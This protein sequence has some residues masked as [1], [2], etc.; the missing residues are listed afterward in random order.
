[1]LGEAEWAAAE[2]IARGDH[3]DPF[4]F[5]GMHVDARGGALIVRAFLPQASR[6]AVVD[7]RTGDVIGEL[8][9]VHEEGLFAGALGQRKEPFPYRLRLQAAN[10]EVELDDPYGF[11]PIL[12]EM[13]VHLLAEGSDERAYE[14]LGAHPREINGVAGV[15]FAVWAPNARR[16]SVVG[17]FND[18]DGRRHAMRL[19][20]EC[21]VWEIFMPGLKQGDLYKY[22]IKTGFGATLPLK[23]DPFGFC[24]E[25]PPATASRVYD[26]G[27][28]RWEDGPWLSARERASARDAPVAIYEVHLGSWRR[29][30]EQNNRYLTYRELA[31]EL[32]AYVKEMG[33]THI[34]LLPVSEYP[35]DGSWGYQPIGLFA[36]TSRFGSPDDFRALVE[37]CHGHGIGVLIDWVP[38]HFPT[39][40]HGLGYFDGTHLYE[41]AD[42]R[43]G[44]HLDWDTLIYN[45]GRREVGNYLIS[46]A[47]LWLD[48]YHVDGLRVDAVAS[49]LYLDYSR[50]PGGWIPNVYGGNENL[51]AIAFLRRLNELAYGK[52][53][54]AI[55]IAEESTAWPMVSRPTYLGGL[56]FGYK[57]NM[58]WMHDTLHYMS[59][60]PVHRRYHHDNLTFGMLYAFTE[61]FILPLSH[62][63][64]VHG[65]GSLLGRMPGDRW[66]KFAN[67]R[68]YFA[69][70]YTHPGKKL[71]FMG[72]EFAQE[73]EWNH[74]TGLEWHLLDDPMHR[75][76]QALVRDL[77]NLYRS[78]PALHVLDCEWQGFEWIDCTNV[79][80]SVVSYI[81]RGHEP[82][83]FVVVVCNFTPVVR[84]G[85][86][87]GVPAAG[88]YAE[89]LNTDAAEYGGSGVGNSGGVE[90]QTIPSHGRPYS[91]ALTLPPLAALVLQPASA[92]TRPA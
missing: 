1:M 27:G 37:R 34:E 21:G 39:D 81:R 23:A 59:T 5:L 63:E 54:G 46:N 80:Q 33:F 72:G 90:A 35:F 24:A 77:N 88:F 75:S 67:L 92:Q 55:T 28:Y 91:L 19:R 78:T 87:I 65:K 47:L 83:D 32:P 50:E 53:P 51:E 43:A 69:F 16:V 18:W 76:V 9:R 14:K 38:G 58:G 73:R 20:I 48:Q 42:P 29:K 12:G 79:E 71:L 56:G 15:A 3:G 30:P 10:G 68:A 89:R 62:D 11:P 70:M 7:T 86:R 60:D 13:D 8:P 52:A 40:P 44:W 17:P 4:S 25:K 45:Y 36:P 41:H 66:Q 31:E 6:A 82:H 22:E 49:M 84:H 61:N 64:V 26:L 2:A 74:D 57:W 85:Y